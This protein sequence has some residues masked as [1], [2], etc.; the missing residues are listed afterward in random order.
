MTTPTTRPAALRSFRARLAALASLSVLGACVGLVADD[1]PAAAATAV[2]KAVNGQVITVRY[3]AAINSLRLAPEKGAGYERSAFKLW[4]DSDHDC[5]DTRAEVLISESRTTTT[6]SCTIRTGRWV[7]AYDGIAFTRASDLDIDHLVPLA[8]AWGS[9]ARSWSAGKREAYA[10]DLTESKSL[11]AVSAHANRSKGDQ[12][13]AEWQPLKNRCRYLSNWVAVKLRW[14]LSIDTTEK[15]ALLLA[16]G[17]CGNPTLT[18]HHAVVRNAPAGGTTTVSTGGTTA[19]GSGPDPR[20]GTC[21]EA[22]AAG[23]G[24]YVRGVDPEYDWYTDR[25][26]DGIVC[27]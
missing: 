12:D 7:S 19:G 9:G 6:G 10:N 20:F 15:R 27:E 17:R 3:R 14:G 2:P 13:P 21:G 5:R 25:D 8:E 22:I 23:Y 4:D 1:G 11:I 24:P 26:G 16:T 18:T